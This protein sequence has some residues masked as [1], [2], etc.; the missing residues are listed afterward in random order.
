[1]SRHG[2]RC[3]K[4]TRR[5][6]S[7]R[8]RSPIRCGCCSRRAPPARRRASCTATAACVLE[9]LKYLSLHLDL[10]PDDRFFWQSTTSWMMWNL[11]VS[12]LLVGAT[13]VLYDGSPTYPHTDGLWQVVA[14]HD[15][16]VFGA[17]AGYLLACAK[18]ELHPGQ[19]LP[20]RRAARGRRPPVRR[21]P[22]R[23]SAGFRTVSAG[24]SRWCRPAAA[25]TW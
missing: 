11:L 24:R 9:H 22:P 12:G 16:T 6:R 18:E 23:V 2:R 4:P 13:V 19:G 5:W 14:D 1:M 7:R 17:G 20:A 10:K 21:C 25:P 15:V 8:S 3:S